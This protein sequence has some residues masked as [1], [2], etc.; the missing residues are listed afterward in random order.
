MR[1]MSKWLNSS[2]SYSNNYSLSLTPLKEK[3]QMWTSWLFKRDCCSTSVKSQSLTP[4][5]TWLKIFRKTSRRSWVRCSWRYGIPF[6]RTLLLSRFSHLMKASKMHRKKSWL[7]RERERG[8]KTSS[9]GSDIVS[10]G[11]NYRSWEMMAHPLLYRIYIKQTLIYT[12]CKRI[13]G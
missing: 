7:K 9:K 4:S 12:L 1:S 13:R 8:D 3:L 2:S 5:S 10:S 6:S 11:L